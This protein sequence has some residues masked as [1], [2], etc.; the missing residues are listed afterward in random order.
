MRAA[1][2]SGRLRHELGHDGP[3]VGDFVLLSTA[4]QAGPARIDAV[5]ERKSWFRRKLPGAS[6]RAQAIAANVDVVFVVCA[7][8]S[9]DAGLHAARRG[10]NP[11]RIERY[12]HAIREAPALA[13]VL[14]NKADLCA[15]ASAEARELAAALAGPEVLPVSAKSGLGLDAVVARIAAG[16]TALFVGSSGAGKSS[17]T[18]RLLG[19]AAQRVEAER[20][21]D[22]RGRHTTTERALLHLPSGGVLIDTPGMR[23]LALYTE[24][25]VAPLATG[26]DDI[27]LLATRCRYRDCRHE[28]EPG[29]AVREAVLRGELEATRVEHA[30]RLERELSWQKARHDNRLRAAERKASKVLSRALRVH[31]RA[32]D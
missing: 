10:V 29:C 14:L 12:L 17:L 19:S 20:A 31:K 32:R 24:N 5:L 21:A 7:L 3:C 25:E 18:N 15:D 4:S 30:R 13:V 1:Q 22:G 11:R 26:F 6:S 27:D 23:E 28:S 16:D 8:T 2:L 9:S